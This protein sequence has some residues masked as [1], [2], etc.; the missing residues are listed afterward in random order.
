MAP[1]AGMRGS[2]R[3]AEKKGTAALLDKMMANANLPAAQQ[4]HLRAVAAGARPP[5]VPVAPSGARAINQGQHRPYADRYAGIALNPN[6]APRSIKLRGQILVETN[7]YARDQ[8]RTTFDGRRVRSIEKAA[9]QDAY[10]GTVEDR[11]GGSARSNYAN[12][13]ADRRPRSETAK[14][15]EAISEEITERQEFLAD[16][17]AAGRGQ[18]HEAQVQ[19]EIS[20]RLQEL[21]R[22]EELMKDE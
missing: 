6:I 5:P 7:G 8:Y 19:R 21:R 10:L 3:P 11:E 12:R 2:V 17:R 16:M 4:R 14:L 13:G 22:V 9:L 18:A 15:H 1:T 20:E